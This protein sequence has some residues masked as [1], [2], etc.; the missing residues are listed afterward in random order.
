MHCCRCGAEVVTELLGE[1]LD[2]GFRGVV[3]WVSGGVGDAL[4][5]TGDDYCRGRGLGADGREKGGYAVDDTE[6]VGVYD[7]QNAEGKI[8]DSIPE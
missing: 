7:L 5:G 2:R 8:M 1:G 4:L 3:G 6:E